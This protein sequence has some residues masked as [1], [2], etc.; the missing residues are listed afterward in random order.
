MEFIL[1]ALGASGAVCFTNPL[2]V[3]KTRFQLQGELK[4][5]GNYKVHY[6]NFA[7]A[8]YVF[9]NGSRLGI[10][11]IA[12]K[13]KWLLKKD[14]NISLAK[15]ALVGAGAGMLGGFLASPLGL[16]KIHFQSNS[17]QSIAVGHQHKNIGTIRGLQSLYVQYGVVRGLWRGAT[18]AM[19]R[20]GVASAMQLS[21]MGLMNEALVKH[22]L[23][24]NDQKVLCTLVSSM[25]GGILM[26]V[27]MAPF[28][29]VSTRL[30]N[31]GVDSNGRGILYKSYLECMTKTFKQEGIHGLYKGVFPCYLRLGPHVVLSMTFWDMLRQVEKKVS[32]RINK[33]HPH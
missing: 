32:N 6:R 13:K 22:G 29:L 11:D 8:L 5:S 19:V 26:A 16:L 30:Y 28:D 24:T 9:L 31:Q 25:L 27:V 17:A 3:V 14:G 21:T 20:I 7:H 4:K 18:G 23:L 10:F 2:E 12:Q 15:S 33:P 1:G